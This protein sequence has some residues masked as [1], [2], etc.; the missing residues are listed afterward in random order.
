MNE[1]KG[2][3]HPWGF[4]SRLCLATKTMVFHFISSVVTG[5]DRGH[6]HQ[7]LCFHLMRHDVFQRPPRSGSPLCSVKKT[8][9]VYFWLKQHQ[10][11]QRNSIHAGSHTE[12]WQRIRL[13]LKI[14]YFVEI[15]F[16][17]TN[18]FY[19][20]LY[21]TRSK[22]KGYLWRELDFTDPFIRKTHKWKKCGRELQET[23]RYAG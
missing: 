3:N 2:L 5:A 22:L 14:K 13:N 4:Y 6:C 1:V 19:I 18:D 11:A 17:L 20:T 16:N 7:C 8:S 15:L 10:V 9:Q 21:G 12:R 23:G